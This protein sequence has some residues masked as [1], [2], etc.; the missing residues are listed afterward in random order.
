MLRQLLWLMRFFILLLLTLLLFLGLQLTM[1][2]LKLLT[3][4][5]LKALP[6]CLVYLRVLLV[7]L[8]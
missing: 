5:V 3:Q 2:L 1:L 7:V 6:H 8:D 4:R